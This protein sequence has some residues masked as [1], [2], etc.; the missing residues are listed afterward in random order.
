[1]PAYFDCCARLLNPGGRILLQAIVVS[2]AIHQNEKAKHSFANLM[3]PGGALPSLASL[4]TAIDRAELEL[5]QVE[6]LT[7]HYVPTLATWRAN[8]E[9]ARERIDELGYDE[10]HV[11]LWRSYL[12]YSEAGFAE[13]R[14]GNMQVLI[15]RPVVRSRRAA[16][17]LSKRRL[18][19]CLRAAARAHPPEHLHEQRIPLELVPTACRV[20]E[21]R[22]I[23]LQR[24]NDGEADVRLA[25]AGFRGE[26]E[27]VG[28]DSTAVLQ[29]R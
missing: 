20:D 18:E 13:R 14:I 28:P 23:H 1:L 12:A 19:R 11:R 4:S 25:G 2:D 8:L 26:H 24:A 15:E 3:F 22:L 17:T 6:D 10:R 21:L 29:A 27:L 9:Q 7:P 16:N 5:V